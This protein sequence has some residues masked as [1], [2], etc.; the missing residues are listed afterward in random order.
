[1]KMPEYN[2]TVKASVLITKAVKGDN[3]ACAISDAVCGV[4]DEDVISAIKNDSV[5]SVEYVAWKCPL[6]GWES[7]EPDRLGKC[8]QCGFIEMEEI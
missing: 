1:M 6:C 5:Y 8:G 3:R 2:V 7:N 4:S